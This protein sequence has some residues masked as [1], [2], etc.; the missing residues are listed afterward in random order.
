MMTMT[1]LGCFA[2]CE[3]Y[4]TGFGTLASLF[5]SPVP[6]PKRTWSLY[7]MLPNELLKACRMAWRSVTTVAKVG[8]RAPITLWLVRYR[9]F[10][11]LVWWW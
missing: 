6:H 11:A 10:S 5:L 9:G 8:G 1:I 4:G 2:H 3:R 7:K